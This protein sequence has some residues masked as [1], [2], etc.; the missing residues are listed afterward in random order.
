MPFVFQR[1][2]A[3]NSFTLWLP[4]HLA[5]LPPSTSTS[6]TMFY[7]ARPHRD[8]FPAHVD[9]HRLRSEV[10]YT[11]APGASGSM[12][13]EG[14]GNGTSCG[15]ASASSSAGAGAVAAAALRAKRQR[16]FVER[17]R[18]YLWQLGVL[19]RPKVHRLFHS[20]AVD[21]KSLRADPIMR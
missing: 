16:G 20:S 11:G 8:P 14:D 13:G 15:D 4:P 19:Q 7:P 6:T 21:A 5:P 9:I 12:G 3:H 1:S 10:R 17:V 18:H 2:L